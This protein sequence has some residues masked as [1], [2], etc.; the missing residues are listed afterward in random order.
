MMKRLLLAALALA[1]VMLIAS[2][3]S[4]LAGWGGKS[5]KSEGSPSSSMERTS[6][7][8]AEG[9]YAEPGRKVGSYGEPLPVETGSFPAEPGARADNP[10]STPGTPA[11]EAGGIRVRIGVDTP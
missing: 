2:H 8:S 3:D 1:A 6:A 10:G 11:F 9:A 4:A 5:E 7:E